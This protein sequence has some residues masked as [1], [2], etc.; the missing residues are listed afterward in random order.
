MFVQQ[1]YKTHVI[2]YNVFISA[3]WQALDCSSHCRWFCSNQDMQLKALPTPQ[4]AP[5]VAPEVY[6]P[7]CGH[8]CHWCNEA[9]FMVH[10]KREK[11]FHKKRFEETHNLFVRVRLHEFESM[12]P[13]ILRL[14]LSIDMPHVQ[15]YCNDLYPQFWP[16]NFGTI[17]HQVSVFVAPSLRTVGPRR[18]CL[19]RSTL[20]FR[21]GDREWWGQI[22]MDEGSNIHRLPR[23]VTTYRLMI[24]QSGRKEGAVT[25]RMVST[26]NMIHDDSCPWHWWY[27]RTPFI[28]HLWGTQHWHLELHATTTQLPNG[29][30]IQDPSAPL[31]FRK[32]TLRLGICGHVSRLDIDF[33]GSGFGSTHPIERKTNPVPLGKTGGY[34]Q[35]R[36]F[37]FWHYTISIW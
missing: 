24:M 21:H 15:C 7:T 26:T 32:G 22:L 14:N 2:L 4:H 9:K 12:M 19:G 31:P 29:H 18:D 3:L 17:S 36:N 37:T 11:L 27:N 23:M 6:L 8:W 16:T 34:L 10:R 33:R 35:L 13:M 25:M 20:V 1:S 5:E 30:N 28:P